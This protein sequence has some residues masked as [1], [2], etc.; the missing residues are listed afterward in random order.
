[1][2]ADKRTLMTTVRDAL[3]TNRAV[4][5]AKLSIH[6]HLSLMALCFVFLQVTNINA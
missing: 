3:Q 6:A 2:I 4:V 5:V 1:M